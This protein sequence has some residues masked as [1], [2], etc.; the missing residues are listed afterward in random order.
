M[1]VVNKISNDAMIRRIRFA[2]LNIRFI[3]MKYLLSF[4]VLRF[5]QF[6]NVAY[7]QHLFVVTPCNAIDHR[8]PNLV[9][10]E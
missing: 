6:L 9:Q 8:L 4:P 7:F 2:I 1:V 3:S 5:C 10:G